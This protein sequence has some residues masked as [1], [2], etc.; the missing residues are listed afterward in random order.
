MR[1]LSQQMGV[2]MSDIGPIQL[3]AFGFGPDTG[4][5]APLIDELKDLETKGLI[6]LLD[7]LFVGADRQT[8]QLVSCDHAGDAFGGLVAALL[9]PPFPG[10]MPEGK[11]NGLTRAQLVAMIRST[12]P[13]VAIGILVIEHVWATGLKRSICD[14]GGVPMVDGYLSADTIAE[15]SIEMQALAR[16]MD[17]LGRQQR[18]GSAVSLLEPSWFEPSA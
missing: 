3:L 13:D 8:D 16:A 1:M 4:S 15:I 5:K 6:R 2:V 18:R 7:V 12:P 17:E 14:A 9:D 10:E 11:A